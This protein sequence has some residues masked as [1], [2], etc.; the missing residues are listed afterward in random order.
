MYRPR[1]YLENKTQKY[2]KRF[3]RATL[4]KMSDEEILRYYV[5]LKRNQYSKQNVSLLMKL[6]NYLLKNDK[7]YIIDNYEYKLYKLTNQEVYL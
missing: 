5:Y 7:L 1:Q 2:S 3:N 4:S 6:N